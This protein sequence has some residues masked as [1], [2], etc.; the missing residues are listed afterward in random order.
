M[1][2]FTGLNG[3]ISVG[4]IGVSLTRQAKIDGIFHELGTMVIPYEEIDKVVFSKGGLTNGYMVFLRKG[5]KRPHSVFSAIKNEHA[6]VFRFTK[7][8]SAKEIVNIVKTRI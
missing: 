8:K 3:S 7:N 1:R 6:I 2:L 5:E 4:E